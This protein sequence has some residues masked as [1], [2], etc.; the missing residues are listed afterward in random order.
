MIGYIEW[1]SHETKEVERA[2]ITRCVTKDG[3]YYLEFSNEEHWSEGR[4][5]LDWGTEKQRAT[6]MYRFTDDSYQG[7]AELIGQISANED[8]IDFTGTWHDPEDETGVWD[9]YIEFEKPD[10]I[11]FTYDEPAPN[12]PAPL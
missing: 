7:N 9:V 8:V 5:A 12:R 1:T 11:T 4:V 2:N 10:T 6:G 3:V